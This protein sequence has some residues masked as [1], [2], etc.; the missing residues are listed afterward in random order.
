MP[1]SGQG[2]TAFQIGAQKLLLPSADLQTPRVPGAQS[3]Q[4]LE[5]KQPGAAAEGAGVA[6]EAVLVGGSGGSEGVG[7]V[8]TPPQMSFRSA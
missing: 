1:Q 2:S 3:S 7:V 8:G 4:P 5:G 6:G